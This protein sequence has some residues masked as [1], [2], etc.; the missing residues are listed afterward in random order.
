M[1]NRLDIKKEWNTPSVKELS[2]TMTFGGS[3]D[4]ESLGVGHGPDAGA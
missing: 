4:P 1:E 3:G 2:I